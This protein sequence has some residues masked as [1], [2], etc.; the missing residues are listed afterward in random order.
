MGDIQ[1]RSLCGSFPPLFLYNDSDH[2]TQSMF[3]QPST[4]C[5]KP[6]LRLSDVFLTSNI[7]SQKLGYVNLVYAPPNDR[8]GWN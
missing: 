8:T 7:D 1:S 4:C 6:V 2:T 5:T 3:M